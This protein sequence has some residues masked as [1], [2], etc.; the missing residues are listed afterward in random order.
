MS[1]EKIEETLTEREK[2]YGEFT[3]HAEI[4]QCLKNVLKKAAR[5]EALGFDQK[6]AL[7]MIMLC[8][9]HG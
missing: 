6:E 5:W 4:T 1:V 7:E 2:R 3:K 8:H 9:S